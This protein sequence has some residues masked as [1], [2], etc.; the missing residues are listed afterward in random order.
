[1]YPPL[2]ELVQPEHQA[3]LLKQVEQERLLRA[4]GLSQPGLGSKVN[5]WLGKQMAT[6]KLKLQPPRA[7]VSGC[8]AGCGPQGCAT[9]A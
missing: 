6:L 4:A 3:E 8:C 2:A 9:Q 7:T 1:M 5:A